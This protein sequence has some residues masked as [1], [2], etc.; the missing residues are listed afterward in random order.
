MVGSTPTR[1]RHIYLI[2]RMLGKREA[3]KGG[4]KRNLPVLRGGFSAVRVTTG[5]DFDLQMRAQ[6][7]NLDSSCYPNLDCAKQWKGVMQ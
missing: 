6:P 7:L 1:F 2:R 4:N 5:F 3:A